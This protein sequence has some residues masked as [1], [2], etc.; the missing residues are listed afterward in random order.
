MP[1]GIDKCPWCDGSIAR[2]RRLEVEAMTKKQARTKQPGLDTRL[3]SEL[4]PEDGGA[5][6][7]QQLPEHFSEADF[8]LA[9]N[10][11]GS[12]GAR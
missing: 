9:D 7:Q 10:R 4:K 3:H 12:G 8:T 5:A 2:S 11:H 6:K 1:H